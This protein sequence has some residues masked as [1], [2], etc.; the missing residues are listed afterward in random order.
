MC[1]FYRMEMAEIIY[2]WLVSDPGQGES[3]DVLSWSYAAPSPL[4]LL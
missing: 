2:H 4:G 1:L 3:F